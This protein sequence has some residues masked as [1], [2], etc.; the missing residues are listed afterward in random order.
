MTLA[1]RGGLTV[2]AMQMS[3]RNDKLI[4][5]LRSQ[6]NPATAGMCMVWIVLGT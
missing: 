4:N 6:A 3:L 5:A 2:V 1:K